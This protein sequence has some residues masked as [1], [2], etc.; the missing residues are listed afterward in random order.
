MDKLKSD[1][2]VYISN[3][4]DQYES[5]L[6]AEIARL[7]VS[8]FFIFWPV[9]TTFKKKKLSIATQLRC[10]LKDVEKSHESKCLT[11]T[12]EETSYTT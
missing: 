10:I 8:C 6:V 12:Y 3:S 7:K 2:G 1:I 11:Q 5:G 9:I 4:L